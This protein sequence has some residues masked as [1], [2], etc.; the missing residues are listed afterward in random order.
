MTRLV[1]MMVGAVLVSAAVVHPCFAQ[2]PYVGAS[3]GSDITRFNGVD[4]Q[5]ST[6]G[7]AVSWQLTVG[8]PI[9][10]HFGVELEFSRPQELTQTDSGPIIYSAAAT[11]ALAAIGIPVDFAPSIR[12]AQRHTTIAT[13]MWVR[14]T[15]TP[16]FSLSYHGGVAFF[17]T[18]NDFSYNF[19]TP[20]PRVLAPTLLPRSTRTIEYGASPVV[21][22]DGRIG[23][24]EQLQLVPALRMQTL[25]GGW[26]VRPSVGVQWDF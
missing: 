11:A 8:T 12:T 26:L 5:N 10:S 16:R 6:G 7:E 1:Q 22:I 9:V 18:T 2:G 21:G 14:Q 23:M 25:S 15:I 19:E 17:R 24:T 13:T 4:G 20:P 3:V